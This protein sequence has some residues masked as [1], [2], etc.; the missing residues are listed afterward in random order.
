[1]NPNYY[2]WIEIQANKKII[3]DRKKFC[4]VMK[5]CRNA[6]IGAVILGVKDTTGFALYNSKIAPHYREYDE[7]FQEK[8][9]LLDCL[10]QVHDLGMKFY[11]AVDVFAEG[12][13]RNPHPKMPGIR[14]QDWQTFVYGLNESNEPSIQPVSQNTPLKTIGSIDD[15]GEIFVNPGKE[16]VCAYELSLIDEIMSEYPVDGIVLDR[17]R[18]VGLS[19]DFSPETRKQWEAFIEE[20]SEWPEDIY[21]FTLENEET[22]IEYG[23]RFGDFITF[24]A[25]KIRNFIEQVRELVDKQ[26][27]KIDFLDYTGSWYPLY[28]QV[29]AN[30]ASEHYPVVEYPWVE[31]G[32]YQKTGY[33][34]KTDGLLSG[35]Y[36]PHVSEQDAEEANQP[37]YWYS[38]EGSAKLAARVTQ[39]TVPVIGSLFLDQYRENLNTITDAVKMCFDKSSG[40]MLFDLCYLEENDWWKYVTMEKNHIILEKMDKAGLQEL[41]L[42][43]GE[44]FPQEFQVSEDRLREVVF[45]DEDFCQEASLAVRSKNNRELL[46]AILCK[47]SKKDD[48][49]F[50]HCAWITALLVKPGCRNLGYGSRL[51]QEAEKILAGMGV[52]KV[53]AGQDLHN[54]F[55]GIPSPSLEKIAFFENSGFHINGEDHYDLEADITTGEQLDKFDTSSYEKLYMT[56]PL[57]KAQYEELYRFLSEEFPGRWLDSAREYLENGG[58][59]DNIVILRDRAEHRIKGFCM[60]QINQCNEGGLGPI[61]IAASIRGNRNGDFLL[62]QSLLHLRKKGA[63]KVGIDWTILKDFYGKFGFV[64]IRVYRSAYKEI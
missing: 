44:C 43:W 33:A 28:Y 53:F 30:W 21:R 13:K 19:S 40:C 38:V 18:Y 37:A 46:G 14:N 39:G 16:E 59:P 12:N 10:Q 26:E 31:A 15:F 22:K 11:A 45:Q 4:E 47:R 23:K 36:Y 29:G 20:D 64:P 25:G 61:G 24:R 9:Y 7:I 54:I 32:E 8:D 6:G 57:K 42:L 60:I 3:A 55:S 48:G 52:K 58:K 2:V 62:Q 41:K 35:F 17:V 34:E 5:K 27:R 56:E 1:M 51:Y 50:H 63:E 49:L